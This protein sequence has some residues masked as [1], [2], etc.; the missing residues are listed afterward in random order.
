MYFDGITFYFA[1]VLL[2]LF[3][4]LLII[5]HLLNEKSKQVF[6]STTLFWQETAIPA[7]RLFKGHLRRIR[8]LVFLLCI[9]LVF[10]F[11][12]MKPVL[13]NEDNKSY[14]L[15]V[16][17][18]VNMAQQLDSGI[19][20]L[21]KSK[22]ICGRMIEDMPESASVSLV[23]ITDTVNILANPNDSRAKLDYE[24]AKIEM[25]KSKDSKW[26]GSY[27]ILLSL[28]NNNLEL[29][30]VVQIFSNNISI[31]DLKYGYNDAPVYIYNGTNSKW[32]D[33]NNQNQ[34]VPKIYLD[35]ETPL[36][37]R[38]FLE[39]YDLM[40]MAK[41]RDTADIVI[42]NA[43]YSPN[44]EHKGVFICSPQEGEEADSKII[45]SDH[46][47]RSTDG[48]LADSIDL[49]TGA[50]KV[51][52]IPE[53]DYI[54]LLFDSS[55]GL[56]GYIAND[57]SICFSSSIF[58]ADSTFWKQSQF[59]PIMAAV[60]NLAFDDIIADKTTDLPSGSRAFG[61]SDLIVN[62]YSG[63]GISLFLTV[64]V[65]ALLLVVLDV[66]L[67]YRRLIV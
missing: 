7:N 8:T 19:S 2:L 1:L 52:T 14:L 21:E 50:G 57:K 35:K 43:S 25:A 5:S 60:F 38:V 23:S 40:D 64:A 46:L 66:M 26:I 45:L 3:Y 37:L 61:S 22:E 6:V 44:H 20:L 15:V 39:T 58:A 48:L 42:S 11:L 65:I 4:L 28:I 51:L 17:S 53:G 31:D 27:E 9:V 30:T 47:K 12:L 49:F 63:R 67:Y 59:F 33:D 55:G 10:I 41:S 29:G 62:I 16:D 18:R 36:A 54:P 13:D 56:L 24:L 34:E 32:Y